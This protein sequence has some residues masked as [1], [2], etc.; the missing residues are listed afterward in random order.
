MTSFPS[1]VNADAVRKYFVK[2]DPLDEK[3][4]GVQAKKGIPANQ[5][6]MNEKVRAKVRDEGEK[7]RKLYTRQIENPTRAAWAKKGIPV[8]RK[9]ERE[10]QAKERS[11]EKGSR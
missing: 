1:L 10:V 3:N 2:R 8:D 11:T 6:K 7:R 9:P 5:K 4:K